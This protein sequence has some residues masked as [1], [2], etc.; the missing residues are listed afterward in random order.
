LFLPLPVFRRH[1]E[2]QAKDPR[3][4]AGTN[5]KHPTRAIALNSQIRHSTA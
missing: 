4:G 5:A 1:P 3:I 2:P